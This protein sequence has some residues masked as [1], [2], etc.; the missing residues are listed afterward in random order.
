VLEITEHDPIQDYAALRAALT[1]LEPPVEVAV[2]DAG[3]G[4]ASLRHILA[5]RPR[6]VK[7]DIGWVR[8][9]DADPARQALVAG[10]VHFAGEVGCRLIGEGVETEAERTALLRLGVPLGQG[11][12]FGRPVPVPAPV[13]VSA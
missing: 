4:Y 11:C 10:L 2:D 9:I 3:S 8:G 12:L 7:L 5:L 1:A 6:Y 13:A